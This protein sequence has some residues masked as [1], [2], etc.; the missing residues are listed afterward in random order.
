M[1][2][3]Q[4]IAEL[5]RLAEMLGIVIRNERMGAITGGLCRVKDSF[6]LFI[7]KALSPQS[8]LEFLAG[9]IKKLEWDS[10]YVRPEVR[11]IL[12]S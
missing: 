2:R 10:H 1:K 9:E 5:E 7:N 8:R 4:I 3:K 6:Y 11:K 12:E